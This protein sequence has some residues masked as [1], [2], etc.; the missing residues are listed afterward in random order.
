[1]VIG[2][3]AVFCCVSLWGF[4]RYGMAPVASLSC[5]DCN[6]VF[7]AL[8]P[9]RADA[10]PIY[11]NTR[12]HAPAIDALSKSGFVFTQAYAVAPWTLP[13]VMSLMTGVYPSA[14]RV[15]NKEIISSSDQKTFVPAVLSSEIHTFAEELKSHG[16]VTGGFAGGAALAPSY[17]FNRGFD[18]YKSE[19]TFDGLPQAVPEALAFIRTHQKEKMFVF[20]HGFDVHGQYIPPGG[21]THVFTKKYAGKLTGSAE[22]QKN[23]REEGVTNNNVFL[24]PEDVEYLRGLYDEKFVRADEMVGVI[25]RELESLNLMGRTIVVFTSNHGEEFYEHGRIDHGMTLFD[26]VIHIPYIMVL[27]GVRTHKNIDAQVRNIDIVPTILDLIGQKAGPE[28]AKQLMGV[29]LVPVILGKD[30]KLNVFAETDYRYAVFK[31]AIRTWDQWKLI[32]DEET[33]TK[34]LYNIIKDPHEVTDISLKEESKKSDLITRML[35]FSH[36]DP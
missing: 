15:T 36:I 26:E 11:G 12:V 29:S 30:M 14:H 3:I 2:I 9:L 23:I 34:E 4:S 32:V 1:M 22:E 19:G 31:K 24:T 28:F 17:G 10:L 6:I 7:I 27:P 25:M 21:Y 16:Y 5:P 18:V 13:S 20:I 8:D 35:Q 33:Q